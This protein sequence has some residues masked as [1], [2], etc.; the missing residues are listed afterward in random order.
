MFDVGRHEPSG[1]DL[2]YGG[3]LIQRQSATTREN[4]VC[5]DD[6]G[7]DK[8][9]I[10]DLHPVPRHHLVLQGDPVADA[11]SRF[12]KGMITY[13]AVTPDRGPLHDVCESPNLRAGP[14]LVAFAKRQAM[15]EDAGRRGHG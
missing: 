15:D 11:G 4:I 9:V 1:L 10:S 13:V 7:T 14:N 12:D 3:H 5:K 6:A 8:H 2:V